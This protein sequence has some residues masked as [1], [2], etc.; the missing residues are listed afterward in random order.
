MAMM[1]KRKAALTIIVMTACIA[2]ASSATAH[3]QKLHSEEVQQAFSLGRSTDP[4]TVRQFFEGYSHQF[5]C[6]GSGACVNSI[7]LRTPYEQVALRSRLHWANYTEQ[8]AE[9]DYAARPHLVAVHVFVLYPLNFSDEDSDVSASADQPDRKSNDRPDRKDDASLYGF[10]I[11]AFEE[12][13]VKPT[14]VRGLPFYF[15]GSHCVYCGGEEIIL[16][17][18]PAQLYPDIIHIEVLTP[19]GQTVKSEFDL[20]YLK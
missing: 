16:D 6:P 8:D 11:R 18:D 13:A 20:R 4:D 15:G 7:E 10:R 14:K 2:L 3:M 19:D 5:P 17:F 1:C 12:H 9:R